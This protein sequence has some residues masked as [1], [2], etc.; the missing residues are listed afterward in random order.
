MP[1]RTQPPKTGLPQSIALPTTQTTTLNNGIKLMS[2]KA[3]TQ[4]VL[5]LSIVFR[6]GTR[7]Q[8]APFVASAMLNML[9]EGS[10]GFSSSAIADHLD[11][12][13]IYYDTNIDRDYSM[14]TISCLNKFLGETL[15]LLEDMVTNP[16]FDENELRIYATKRKQNI[17]IE[18]EKP[19]FIAREEFSKALFGESHPYGVASDEALYDSLTRS[20]LLDHYSK[21]YSAD[22]CFAV[23]S[24]MIEED[25]LERIKAFLNTIPRREVHSHEGFALPI[26][27]PEVIVERSGALQSSIRMGKVLFTKSHPDFSAMQILSTVLGGYFGSRLVSNLREDKGYTYGIYSAMVTLEKEGYFAIATDVAAEHTA[28]AVEQIKFEIERLRSELIPT[29][30]LD[31]V[32]NTIIGELMRLIDGPFGIADITI[33]SE[34]CG[35]DNGMVNDF[36]DQVKSV[37]PER[38][39]DMAIE[40]LDPA[41]L[42]TVIVGKKP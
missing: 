35:M 39:L 3:G 16:L 6:A 12:Y 23:C 8:S 13:G 2:L 20:D 5:R 18:R 21:Y 32:R 17:R 41:T 40:Y 37:T 19:S 38:L 29:E 1:D 33:E 7:Y 24:G 4:N 15:T 27:I 9:S 25:E 30:E 36:L 28:Q 31:M 22:N 34:Q 14:I 10:R 26:S 42:T 11:F